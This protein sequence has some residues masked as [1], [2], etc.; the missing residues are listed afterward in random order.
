MSILRLFKEKKAK[1][2][3]SKKLSKP[4]LFILQN[5]LFIKFFIFSVNY[6]TAMELFLFLQND[7]KNNIF[8]PIY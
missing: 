8:K 4:E 7:L 5:E 2:A 3:N 1:T 6:L